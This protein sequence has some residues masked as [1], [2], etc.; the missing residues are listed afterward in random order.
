MRALVRTMRLSRPPVSR[1]SRTH[2][3]ANLYR[4]EQGQR[5]TVLSPGEREKMSPPSRTRNDGGGDNRAKIGWQ[6][7]TARL[8]GRG[9]GVLGEFSSPDK[10]DRFFG[11]LARTDWDEPIVLRE[12]ARVYAIVCVCVCLRMCYWRAGARGKSAAA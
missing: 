3:S 6:W 9:G 2:A 12:S 11:A 1:Y 5:P 7:R 10:D 8:S 4:Y